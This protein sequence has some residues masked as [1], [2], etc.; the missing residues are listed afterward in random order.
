MS[1]RSEALP[2]P[3]RARHTIWKGSN[4]LR[5]GWRLL[6]FVALLVPMFFATGAVSDAI[7]H[8]LNLT[9]GT[10]IGVVSL[11]IFLIPLMLA[12]WIMTR[13]E[14]RTFADYGLPLRR[15]FCRQF[16]QGAAISFTSITILL[17]VLRIL[18]AYSFGSLAL[19]GIDIWKY[20]LLWTVP[21]FI[22]ALLEDFLYRGYL[23]FTL[24]TGIGFWPAAVVTSLLMGGLHYFNPGGHSLGPIAATEYCL[25]T[26]LVLRRTGDLWMPLG[27]HATWSWGE[28]YFYGVQSSGFP[29]QGHLLNPSFHG[30]VSLTGGT[31]GV[32][33]S[34]P[35]LVLLALWG[36]GFSLWLRGTRY[37]NPTAIADPRAK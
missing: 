25:V 14:G 29:S 13:I 16:W 35:S 12:T 10:P 8:R 32:E 18:G 31:F 27:I 28:L 9:P 34:W 24:T 36:I 11:G 17:L 20:A 22:G 26:A 21:V 7:T 37:P 19:Q 23:L 33:A 5:A 6:I 15:A 3:L 2:I 4:G 1:T 30:P